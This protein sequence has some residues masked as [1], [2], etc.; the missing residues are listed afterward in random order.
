[1]PRRAPVSGKTG[2]LHHKGLNA[3]PRSGG[4][5]Y[6]REGRPSGGCGGAA[7]GPWEAEKFGAPTPRK[8][9]S[10]ASLALTQRKRR[11]GHQQPNDD[12]LTSRRQLA[13]ASE[14]WGVECILAVIGTG[15]LVKASNISK[16]GL[17]AGMW[18]VHREVDDEGEQSERRLRTRLVRRRRA[19]RLW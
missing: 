12:P 5:S 4:W 11:P 1:M 19:I 6:C 9:R 18:F 3:L 2:S 13:R 7:E 17:G 8:G 10:L 16:G 15:G 14:V